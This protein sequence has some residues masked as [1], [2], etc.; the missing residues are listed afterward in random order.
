MLHDIKDDEKCFTTLTTGG[1]AVTDNV[2]SKTYFPK[3]QN[4]VLFGEQRNK[5]LLWC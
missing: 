5:V 1:H 2:S 4:G 3:D